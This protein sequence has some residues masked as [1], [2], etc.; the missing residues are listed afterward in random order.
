MPRAFQ[1]P[2]A[3]HGDEMAK[4]PRH[5]PFNYQGAFAWQNKLSTKMNGA[6]LLC[7]KKQRLSSIA[8]ASPFTLLQNTD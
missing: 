8:L 3:P 7:P 1:L 6:Q 4:P 2:T 5:F